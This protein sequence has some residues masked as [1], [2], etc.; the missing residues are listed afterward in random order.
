MTIKSIKVTEKKEF[1]LTQTA[2]GVG[3][4]SGNKDLFRIMKY[5]RD[6]NIIPNITISGNNLDASIAR[7]L[8]MVCGAVAVSHY[9]DNQC[10]NAVKLL[11]DIGMRQINVHQIV[12]ENS[13]QECLNLIDKIKTDPRLEKLNAVV[14]LALKKKGRGTELENLSI[15]KYNI[16]F[17][18]LFTNK[19]RFGMDSCTAPIFMNYLNSY[20]NTKAFLEDSIEPCE[21]LL[22]SFYINVDG[23]GFPCSF[24][25]GTENWGKGL[26]IINCNNFTEDIWNHPKSVE[27]RNNLLKVR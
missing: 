15:E 16:L 9:D 2:L 4:I 21:S 25:E 27:W 17:N 1:F 5:C 10:F 13:Y 20:P 3:S 23:F 18:T 22:M 11:T 14:F 7:N 6:V 19:I 24:I 8:S 26:D 12:H